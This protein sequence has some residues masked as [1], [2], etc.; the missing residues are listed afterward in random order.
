MDRLIY[1]NYRLT[2]RLILISQ[3][4]PTGVTGAE[5]WIDEN[6][7]AE[8]NFSVLA[9]KEAFFSTKDTNFTCN[10]H[11]VQVATFQ[12][13]NNNNSLPVSILID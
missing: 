3:P 11:M 13:R 5:I 7:D 8:G 2:L 6:G 10:H 4:F 9:L 1:E 12:G